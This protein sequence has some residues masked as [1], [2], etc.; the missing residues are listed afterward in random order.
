MAVTPTEKVE[1]SDG[2]DTYSHTIEYIKDAD[3][4]ASVDGVAT[5]AF[6]LKTNQY[7]PIQTTQSKSGCSRYR[8]PYLLLKVT[9]YLIR[10]RESSPC[11]QLSKTKKLETIED[12]PTFSEN[13]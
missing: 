4:K 3:L 2:S 12:A 10:F 9:S 11:A 5:T 7:F 13:Q 8:R 6:T 1:T